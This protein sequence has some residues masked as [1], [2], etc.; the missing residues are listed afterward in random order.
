M[1]RPIR[2]AVLLAVAV[3]GTPLAATAQA[4]RTIKLADLIGAF[5]VD[6]G[7]RTTG[8]PW[9]TGSALPVRWESRAAVSNPAEW[10]HAKG[11]TH[12]RVGHARVTLGDSVVLPLT[13][14]VLGS[15]TGLS[16]V[17]FSFDSLWTSTFLVHRE[18]V[19]TALKND[20]MTLQPLKCSRATE[21]ASYGNLVDAARMPG[22][23]AS[24]L[25]W[26][27]QT[28]QQE[29]QLLLTLLYRRADMAEVECYSG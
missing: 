20:G 25:W 2:L 22:K 5:L 15:A 7:V 21:G 26:S 24:G 27:W 29:S 8:L 16:R 6:S 3:A 17:G 12:T 11:M 13:I 28:V 18:M 19:E 14:S 9:S 23:T 4:A 10:M 1:P